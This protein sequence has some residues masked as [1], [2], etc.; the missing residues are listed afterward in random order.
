[1]LQVPEGSRRTAGQ[2]VQPAQV[3]RLDPASARGDSTCVARDA[4]PARVAADARMAGVRAA[5]VNHG[6]LYAC[7]LVQ[8]LSGYLGSAVSGYPVRYFGM[9]L[10][11]WAPKNSPAQG[12]PE[13]GPSGQQLDTGR[14][15]HAARRRCAETPIRGP[16]PIVAANVAVARAVCR[17]NSPRINLPR[18]VLEQFRPSRRTCPRARYRARS[19]RGRPSA[20]AS[21]LP[22]AAPSR[23]PSC[24]NRPPT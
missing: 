17:A 18:A 12:P 1:M 9:L 2:R 7:L 8:P 3:D 5:H 21:P 13:R 24:R 4:P 19:C 16:R 14:R 22:R 20:R 11:A 15:D 6:L 10:P 23:C